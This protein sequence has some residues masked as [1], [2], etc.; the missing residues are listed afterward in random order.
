MISPSWYDVLLAFDGDLTRLAARLFRTETHVIVVFDHLG[1]D[2]AT[3]EIG[4]NDPG[5]LR[6]L[7]SFRIRPG[8]GFVRAG[9]KIGFEIQQTVRRPDQ[10]G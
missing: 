2:K 7:R 3:F 6:R 9:R 10:P 5:G 8:A 1:A 4:V